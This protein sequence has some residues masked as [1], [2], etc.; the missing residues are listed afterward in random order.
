MS[1]KRKFSEEIEAFPESVT[2][3]EAFQRLYRAFRLKQD[4]IA[5]RSLQEERGAQPFAGWLGKA[6]GTGENPT[7]RFNSHDDLWG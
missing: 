4:R 2:V 6:R 3:E 7:P 5:Q 1:V